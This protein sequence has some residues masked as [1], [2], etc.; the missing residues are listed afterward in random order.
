MAKVKMCAND[1][2]TLINKLLE[3][4]SV[5]EDLGAEGV[6]IITFDTNGAISGTFTIN[7]ETNLLVSIE[8]DGNKKTLEYKYV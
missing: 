2:S 5:L 1:E 8:N 4:G 7:E 6:A 3:M